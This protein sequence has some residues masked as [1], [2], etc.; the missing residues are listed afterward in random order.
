MR[1]IRILYYHYYY[2]L[3][4]LLERLERSLASIGLGLLHSD[5][6]IVSLHL[7]AV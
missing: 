6:G 5:V 7:D 2:Y 3:L 1:Y 4:S